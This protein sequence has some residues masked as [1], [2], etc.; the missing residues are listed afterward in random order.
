MRTPMRHFGTMNGVQLES[1]QDFI[2][3]AQAL[4]VVAACGSLAEARRALQ[5][6]LTEAHSFNLE[7]DL[8]IYRWEGGKWR[9][10]TCL[11]ELQEAELA[12]N[13][14]QLIQLP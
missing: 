3:Y 5:Q 11:Y 6:K 12:R 8:A 9:P 1:D 13:P 2:V 14:S 7:P 10:I 4:G